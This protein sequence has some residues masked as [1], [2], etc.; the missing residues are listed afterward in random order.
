MSGE[1]ERGRWPAATHAR[2]FAR[3]RKPDAPE[4]FPHAGLVEDPEVREL[5]SHL[6]DHYDPRA[7]PDMP[8]SV[9]ETRLYQMLLGRASTETMQT[10]VREGRDSTL[11]YLVGDPGMTADVSGLK[12]IEAIEGVLDKEAPIV[13]IKGEPG[14]GKT[15]I[16]LLLGQLWTRIQQRHDEEYEVASNI[17]SLRAQDRWIERYTELEEWAKEYVEEMEDGGE[18][19][20][21]GAPR[22]LYIL[23]EA[24]SH[25]AGIGEDGF[26]AGTLL[27]P[28]VKKIRKG[29]CGLIIIGHDGKDVHPAVRVLAKVVERYVE[30]VKRATL[31]HGIRNRQGQDRIVSLDGVPQTDWQY[32]DKESTRFVWDDE[33]ED[34]EER[35][36]EAAREAA[37]D[38]HEESR[39]VIAG[40]LAHLSAEGQ[41]SLS[42]ADIGDLCG[43]T[44]SH[45]SRLKRKFEKGTLSTEGSGLDL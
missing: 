6:A 22:K 24:S 18:T 26:K 41:L 1:E 37:Q 32:D 4:P 23:D 15:N 20:R 25:A 45:V 44:Q 27:G 2:E 28:L 19:L 30:D 13:Y 16:A 34:R 33:E 42:Q 43:F 35:I 21:D 31:Y 29:N 9:E 40:Q 14:S 11:S 39:K 5:L 38:A 17:A 10:A 3:G 7:K 12:A 36:E 8:P